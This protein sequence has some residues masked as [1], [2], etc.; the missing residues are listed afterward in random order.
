MGARALAMSNTQVAITND[1]TAG[2]WNP[3]GLLNIKEKYGKIN[4]FYQESKKLQVCQRYRINI[5]K[6]LELSDTR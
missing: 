5:A 4:F 6:I 1:A 2:Y 3:A